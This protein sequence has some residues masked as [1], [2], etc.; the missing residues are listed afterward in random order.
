MGIG[1]LADALGGAAGGASPDP[2]LPPVTKSVI[3]VAGKK[4]DESVEKLLVSVTVVDRLRMPDAFI[5]VFRD[6]AHSVLD[7]A[8]FKVGAK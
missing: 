1:A 2:N 3:E 7:T 5:I 6:E 4:L 8:G